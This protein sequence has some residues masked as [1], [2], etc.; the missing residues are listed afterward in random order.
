MRG[1]SDRAEHIAALHDIVR[2]G[3]AGWD[4]HVPATPVPP[5]GFLSGYA[6]TA[7]PPDIPTPTSPP[8]AAAELTPLVRE[9][10]RAAWEGAAEE[11]VIAR[12]EA[13][14]ALD[15]ARGIRAMA[16]GLGG[17]SGGGGGARAASP[18]QR[19]AAVSPVPPDGARAAVRAAS[20]LRGLRWRAWAGTFGD[21]D[22]DAAAAAAADD[23]A[24]RAARAAAAADVDGRT[25]AVAQLARAVGDDDD[26]AAA[27]VGG[28]PVAAAPWEPPAGGG[29]GQCRAKL[30]VEDGSALSARHVGAA[31]VACGAGVTV[32]FSAR[33]SP[34]VSL[35]ADDERALERALLVLVSLLCERPSEQVF[36]LRWY[37][38]RPRRPPAAVLARWQAAV[39]ATRAA[40]PL[41]HLSVQLCERQATVRLLLHSDGW[42]DALGWR[43]AVVPR[44]LASLLSHVRYGAARSLDVP[45]VG[46]RR[47]AALASP[48]RA[49]VHA[50]SRETGC[51]AL[52]VRKPAAEYAER[53]AYRTSPEG[54]GGGAAA[55]GFSAAEAL[56]VL[57]GPRPAL[58]RAG[59]LVREWEADLALRKEVSR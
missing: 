56:L 42:D 19:A 30:Y 37:L 33:R 52:L 21:D 57:T 14:A 51:A 28:P 43:A 2:R 49:A 6:S 3:H 46:T 39:D 16:A 58:E 54:G 1:A 47:V 29:S 22:G 5:P 10:R 31:Q 26:A 13:Y 40:L 45:L 34:H 20:E 55:A 9:A 8:P 50:L 35:R 15:E 27:A 17:R 41:R 48:S 12:E 36:L 32:R 18:V 24:R 23:G 7:S 4:V 11:S 44:A 53:A 38:H 59:S 25:A